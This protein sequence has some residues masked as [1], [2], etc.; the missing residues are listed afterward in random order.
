MYTLILLAIHFAMNIYVMKRRF[1]D[2]IN[3][4]SVENTPAENVYELVGYLFL[5]WIIHSG[6]WNKLLGPKKVKQHKKENRDNSPAGS[7]RTYKI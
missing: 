1:M 3:S 2:G 6:L 7:Q 4:P 5:G